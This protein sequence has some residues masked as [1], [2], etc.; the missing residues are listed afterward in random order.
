M[1]DKNISK[2]IFAETLTLLLKSKG[3][4]QEDLAEKLGVAQANVSKWCNGTIP[5]GNYAAKIAL[6]FDVPIETLFSGVFP[7]K[8]GKRRID[9]LTDLHK[10]KEILKRMEDLKKAQID[11]HKKVE[12]I[13]DDV[14]KIARTRSL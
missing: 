3:V 2:S 4:R 8:G 14:V 7:E 9:K 6:F 11:Y 10:E 13:M 1:Q 5:R 12:K